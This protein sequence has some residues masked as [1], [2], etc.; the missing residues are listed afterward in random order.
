MAIKNAEFYFQKNTP[1]WIKSQTLSQSRIWNYFV[2]LIAADSNV[3]EVEQNNKS[4]S[5]FV[6]SS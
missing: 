3:E 6:Q 1:M 2:W 4:L 5:L